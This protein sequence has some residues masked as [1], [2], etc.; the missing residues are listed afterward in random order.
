ME[1]LPF[2]IVDYLIFKTGMDNGENTFYNSDIA[3]KLIDCRVK[4]GGNFLPF[5]HIIPESCYKNPDSAK[6]YIDEFCKTDKNV[7]F[8][9][10]KT[11]D[12]IKEE[13]VF[14]GT[15]H[16]MF[17]KMNKNYVSFVTGGYEVILI[18]IIKL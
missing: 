10:M 5:A 2:E 4:K 8:V 12:K 9:I 11:N 14:A 7:H 6:E 16:E 3:H 18:S 1:I 13:S 15:I 17:R